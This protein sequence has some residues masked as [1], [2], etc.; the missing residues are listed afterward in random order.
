MNI[1]SFIFI[2]CKFTSHKINPAIPLCQVWVAVTHRFHG[3]VQ[4]RDD[5]VQ[6]KPLWF[7]CCHMQIWQWNSVN[8]KSIIHISY[9]SKFRYELSNIQTHGTKPSS[10]T[11]F[12]IILDTSFLYIF[13][14]FH[15][16]ERYFFSL[17]NN[18]QILNLD[19]FLLSSV[20]L[21]Y[22]KEKFKNRPNYRSFL[23]CNRRIFK[24]IQAH[25]LIYYISFTVG[26]L[27]ID[28]NIYTN[29]LCSL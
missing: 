12:I 27:C 20:F 24:L 7:P 4:Y 3:I 15:S 21:K 1:Q 13:L 17:S 18:Y 8:K 9:C 23:K 14:F 16:S 6:M 10:M 22:A 28:L 25:L 19:T 2:S 26:H 11:L 29:Q 5:R